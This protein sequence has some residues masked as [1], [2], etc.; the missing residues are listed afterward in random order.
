MLTTGIELPSR[1]VPLT[2]HIHE[3]LFGCDRSHS[4]LHPHRYRALNEGGFRSVV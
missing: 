1:L 3:M 4:R 2:W